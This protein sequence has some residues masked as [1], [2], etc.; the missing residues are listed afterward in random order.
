MT[1]ILKGAALAGSLF[2][3]AVSPVRAN[4]L[5]GTVRDVCGL[6]LPGTSVSV[7]NE[8][9]AAARVAAD[10]SGHFSLNALAPGQWTITFELLGFQTLKQDIRLQQNGDA[11]QL[12]VR[13]LPDL[14]MKTELVMSHED[15]KVRYRKYSVFGVV[16]ARSGEPIS[17]ATVRL[18]DVGSK[19]DRGTDQ[20]TTDELGRYAIAGWS[21]VDTKWQLSV[22]AE[23]FRPYAHP[24]FILGPDKPRAIDLVIEKLKP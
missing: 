10:G 15:P 23:G 17:A 3:V 11:M 24:A 8:S 12:N 21:P 5:A 19:K 22:Q 16:K 6:T 2:V 1:I 4:E 18:Q 7:V 20:C 9:G 14:L 13:L